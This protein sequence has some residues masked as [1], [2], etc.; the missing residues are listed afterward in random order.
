ML[1]KYISRTLSKRVRRESLLRER[2]GGCKYEI[3]KLRRWAEQSESSAGEGHDASPDRD[4]LACLS[5]CYG[6]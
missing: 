3:P 1:V 5:S 2:Y 4:G 6:A